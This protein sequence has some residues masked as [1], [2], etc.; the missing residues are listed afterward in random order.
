[1]FRANA[2]TTIALLLTVNNARAAAPPPTIQAAVQ[3]ALPL[4]LNGAKGHIRKRDCFACHNQALA[5]LAL[6]TARNRGFVVRDKDITEQLDHITTFLNTNR[7]NYLK[8]RGQGGQADTAGYALATLE[9]GGGKASATTSAVVE[10]LLQFKKDVDHWT[11]SGDRPPSE[12]SHFT[13]T[14]V[15]LRGL[16]K[17]GPAKQKERIAKRIDTVRGWLRKTA[18]R[19]TEDR[20]FRLLSLREAGVP[21]REV[22]SAARDL[23]KTQRADGGWGQIERMDSDAYATGSALFALHQAGALASTDAE[24]RRGVAFLMKSQLPDG[25][26][27]IRSRSRPFQT[28]YESGFPHGKNQF[29]SMAATGWAVT[30]LA[31][32][33]PKTPLSK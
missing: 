31:L 18:A 13:T 10:Y 19:D 23:L 15:A 12:A 26:W 25:S 1:M 11:P 27:L 3:R 22:H 14:F 32:A 5:V 29:I 7:E 6:D 9:W 33:C 4:L 16:R 8:G 2:W 20:V 30:A 28:Y 17:W 21:D 24:Y